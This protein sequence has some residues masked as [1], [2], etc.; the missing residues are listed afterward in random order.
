M[1]TRSPLLAV[2]IQSRE[3]LQRQNATSARTTQEATTNTKI[4]ASADDPVAAAEAN[5]LQSRLDRLA[6]FQNNTKVVKARLDTAAASLKSISDFAQA[7]SRAASTVDLTSPSSVP[8][9]INQINSYL[10]QMVQAANARS[11]G[12][13]VLGGSSGA[14]PVQAIRDSS[15]QIIGVQLAQTGGSASALIGEGGLTSVSAADG[16]AIFS[17]PPGSQN[18]FQSLMDLRSALS[19]RDRAGLQTAQ[20]GIVS[21]RARILTA[22]GDLGVQGNYLQQVSDTL[23]QSDLNARERLSAIKDIDLAQISIDLQAQANQFRLTL[24]ATTRMFDNS[25]LDFL[26]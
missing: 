19:N 16:A 22:A 17:G 13:P 2:L 11:S 1:E 15:G 5:E 26:G 4:L 7:A 20:G 24:A 18:L 12:Q 9:A 25:L 6:I 3:Q 21:G 23:D 10:E 14:E 8:I